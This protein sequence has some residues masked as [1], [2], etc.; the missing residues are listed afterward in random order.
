MCTYKDYHITCI[1]LSDYEMVLQCIE[2][3]S[4]DTL[5]TYKCQLAPGACNTGHLSHNTEAYIKGWPLAGIVT[6]PGI[7][8]WNSGFHHQGIWGWSVQIE[9]GREREEERDR[10]REEK[11]EEI[12]R[13]REGL[14]EK[15]R[16]R[17][18][19]ERHNVVKRGMAIPH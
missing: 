7:Q 11:E 5:G 6:I 8:H 18:E 16:K 10:G 19:R 9:R 17:E 4:S 3:M 12:V 2:E 1:G 14:G 13:Q 15:G